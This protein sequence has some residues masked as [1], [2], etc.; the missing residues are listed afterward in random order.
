M[1]TTS[2]AL[3]PLL[4]QAL[5]DVSVASRIDGNALLLDSGLRLTRM[6]WPHT[7]ATTAAGRPPPSSKASI[8]CCSLTACSVPARQRYR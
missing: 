6:R 3:L 7:R 5:Q 2:T 4:Q 8:R 1:T